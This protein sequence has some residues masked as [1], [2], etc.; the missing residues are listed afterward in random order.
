MVESTRGI[1][2]C[3]TFRSDGRGLSRVA[4]GYLKQFFTFSPYFHTILPRQSL[5]S[6]L[7]GL[8]YLILSSGLESV[9]QTDQHTINVEP[10]QTKTLSK[11]KR[12]LFPRPRPSQRQN[13]T[14]FQDQDPLKGKTLPISKT[15]TLSKAKRYLFP[16]PRPSQRQNVTYFQDQDPLKGKTLPISKTKTL[17]KAKRYLFP[18]PR[19]SQ[20]QNVTY[21]QDQ[22]PL[23]GKTGEKGTQR[24]SYHI[25]GL[26]WRFAERTPWFSNKQTNKQTSWSINLV[27]EA[28]ITVISSD[29]YETSPM[30][31]GGNRDSAQ[32]SARMAI[33]RTGVQFGATVFPLMKKKQIYT[34]A[35]NRPNQELLVPDWLI[36][37][38]VTQITS[39]DWLF[40]CFGRFLVDAF[41]HTLTST[42]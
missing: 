29:F 8:G 36:T 16:R 3:S 35:R 31:R 17:S 1:L 12:Y 21:F 9:P 11:A 22:D 25:T 26:L 6:F 40:T 15:K 39:S 2:N 32:M 14:Y 41:T 20:R 23:K 18:R 37:S 33:C 27:A 34:D 5:G 42:K 38:H 24:H 10:V 30:L 13:V 19:P 28:I 7:G 4:T